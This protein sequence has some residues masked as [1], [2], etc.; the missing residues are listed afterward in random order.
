MHT[1][2]LSAGKFYASASGVA[3]DANDRIIYD[4]DTGALFY[5]KNGSKAGGAVQFAELTDHL[6]ISHANFE[7]V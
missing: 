2:T 7:I 5:D 3:H 6:A 1:G 4:T